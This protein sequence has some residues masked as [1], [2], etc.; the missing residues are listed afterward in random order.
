MFVTF[1]EKGLIVA[2]VYYE[3]MVTVYKPTE[4][5]KKEESGGGIIGGLIIG[6]ICNNPNP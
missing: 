5:E 3:E 1:S 4:P 2:R 6:Y